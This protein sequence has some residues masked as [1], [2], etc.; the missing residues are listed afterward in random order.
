M[1]ASRNGHALL[2]PGEGEVIEA[3][4]TRV[5][6]KAASPSQLVCE[7]GA[8]GNFPGQPLHVHPG[9]DETFMVLEGRLELT[10]REERSEL[11]AGATAYVG[12]C[13]PHT[14]RNP[15]AE[16]ARYLIVCSPGGFEHY[17]RAVATGDE[18]MMAAICERFG[19]RELQRV[20]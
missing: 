2:G 7:Y 13:V 12:G 8:P 5:V 18:E 20:G 16:P 17:F 3:G 9:F 10:V 15:D 1:N 4:G 6:I 14:F 11:T 19:Y